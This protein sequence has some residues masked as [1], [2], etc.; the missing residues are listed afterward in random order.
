LQA[1]RQS[2]KQAALD[3]VPDGAPTSALYNFVPH[4]AHRDQIY[5]FPVPWRNVNW[6]VHGEHLAD[7]ADVQWIVVDRRSLGPDDVALLKHLVDYQF[8]VVL[9]RDDIVVAR[10]VHAPRKRGSG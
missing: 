2:A 7:P 8:R 1:D 5:D 10:R 9:D 3:V 6:G 4:L